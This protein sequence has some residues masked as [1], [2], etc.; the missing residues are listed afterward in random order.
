[1][2]KGLCRTNIARIVKDM[3]YISIVGISG[4]GFSCKLVLEKVNEDLDYLRGIKE[5][6][7]FS[8]VI[9]EALKKEE[10]E[11]IKEEISS[12]SV[13]ELISKGEDAI[14]RYYSYM[15]ETYS[16]GNNWW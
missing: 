4:V 1:M 12:V 15:E 14:E 9:A 5:R 6:G 10:D 8:S 7:E 11:D 2:T 16:L 13:D 3:N